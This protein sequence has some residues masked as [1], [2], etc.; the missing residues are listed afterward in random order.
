MT[1]PA[2][3]LQKAKDFQALH[4]K[5]SPLVLYNIWDAGGAA[6]LAA[7]G[8]KAVATGSASVA[9]AHGYKD[10]EDIPL[11][12]VLTIAKC[13][14]GSVSIPVSIDF[15][16]AYAAEPDG[17]KTNAKR[18]IEAG[19]VGCNF[20]DQIVGGEGLYSIEDQSAR[21]AAMKAAADELG[22]DFFINARTDLFLKQPDPT[23]HANL[24]PEALDRASV[25]AEA[26]ASGFFIPALSDADLIARLCD[27][28]SLPVNIYKMKGVPDNEQLASLG[29]A[30]IS[31]GPGPYRQAIKDLKAR[32]G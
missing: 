17:V 28:V 12:L 18:L 30:R 20:E 24:I 4:I 6:A 5:G 2:E 16:G 32:R 11:D 3:Q 22:L 26:G 1:L 29:A 21:I 14:T 27:E 7:E 31:Y 8:D 15:E 13:I 23:K 19:A 25:Y 9:M 10:G